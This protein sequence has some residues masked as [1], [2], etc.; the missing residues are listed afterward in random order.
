M[1]TRITMAMLMTVVVD[2]WMMKMIIMMI[3]I[4]RAIAFKIL[5][6]TMLLVK[7]D[8][9]RKVIGGFEGPI[10]ERGKHNYYV[11]IVRLSG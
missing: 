11:D 7:A 2:Y 9:L 4:Y 5:V 10:C 3:M 8:L 1:V 6:R